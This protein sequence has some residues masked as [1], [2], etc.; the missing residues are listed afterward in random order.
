MYFTRQILLITLFLV[1][2]RTSVVYFS[3]VGQKWLVNLSLSDLCDILCFSM[4]QMQ[5]IRRVVTSEF[6]IT[7]L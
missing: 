1:E 2:M 7:H 3:I 6:P 4:K 5:Y